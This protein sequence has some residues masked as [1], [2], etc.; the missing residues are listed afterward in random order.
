MPS[1]AP[2][3][4]TIA[5]V[6]FYIFFLGSGNIRIMVESVASKSNFPLSFK[7]FTLNNKSHDLTEPLENLPLC[8][9]MS[10]IFKSS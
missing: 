8:Q 6:T 3:E 1:I 7:S 4:E 9:L 2:S 10:K 5:K